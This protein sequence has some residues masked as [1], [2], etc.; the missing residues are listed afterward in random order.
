[1][2]PLSAFSYAS[3]LE[4][5]STLRVLGDQYTGRFISLQNMQPVSAPVPFVFRS[6]VVYFACPVQEKLVLPLDTDTAFRIHDSV[7]LHHTSA[8]HIFVI[9]IGSLRPVLGAGEKAD[10]SDLFWQKFRHSA[11][12]ILENAQFF[13]LSCEQIIGYT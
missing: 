5:E 11:P 1:M 13:R 7:P 3:L 6:G 10:I 9:C 4:N 8:L 12:Q 2:F